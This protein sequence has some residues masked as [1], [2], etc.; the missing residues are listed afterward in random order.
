M[1]RR[2]SLPQLSFWSEMLSYKVTVKFLLLSFLQTNIQ[3]AKSCCP[4][5]VL[6]WASQLMLT[7]FLCSS[8]A[9]KDKNRRAPKHPFLQEIFDLPPCLCKVFYTFYLSFFP[10]SFIHSDLL[11]GPVLITHE[12]LLSLQSGEEDSAC[13]KPL[14]VGSARKVIVQPVWFMVS[15]WLGCFPPHSLHIFVPMSL[16]GALPCSPRGIITIIFLCQ[17]E[18]W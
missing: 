1:R 18:W 10:N 5:W 11:S 16:L 13:Q 6:A 4:F 12:L 9:Q 3:L 8:V 15:W 2:K 7:A 14:A 17:N